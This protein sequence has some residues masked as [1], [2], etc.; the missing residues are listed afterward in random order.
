MRIPRCLIWVVLLVTSAP[1]HAV[2][3]D[4]QHTAWQ[5]LLEQH[6]RW[7]ERGHT[8]WVDYPG[9]SASQTDLNRYLS[10]LSAVRPEVFAEWSREQRLAFLIN[11]Y[12]AFTVKLVL[13]HYPLKSIKN[14]GGLFSSPWKRSFI[15]LLGT[16]VSLDDIEHGMIRAPG[17]YDEP[18]IHFAVN[19]AS[20]GCPALRPEA[21]TAERLDVQLADA[22]RR[23]LTDRQ[24]NGYDAQADNLVLSKIFDWYEQDFIQGWGSLHAFSQAHASMLVDNPEQQ[25]RLERDIRIVFAGYDWTLNER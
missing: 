11:A 3:F 22:T 9:F 10:L 1:L 20:I 14:I 7:D 6:V 18:R 8:S 5:A 19:C 4:Q 24:R 15:P 16:S 25:A 21:Y 12:N 17:V 23:F 2:S 13:E